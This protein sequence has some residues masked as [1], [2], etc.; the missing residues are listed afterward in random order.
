MHF[1]VVKQPHKMCCNLYMLILESVSF[2]VMVA[3]FIHNLYINVLLSQ[4]LYV[5]G[6][7]LVHFTLVMVLHSFDAVLLHFVALCDIALFLH[8]GNDL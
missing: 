4:T 1:Y 8:L 7:T 5:N 2:F 6:M 3:L